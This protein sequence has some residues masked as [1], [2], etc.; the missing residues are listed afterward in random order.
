MKKK[1]FVT[2][3]LVVVISML[4]AFAPAEQEKTV[5]VCVSWNEKVHSLIQAWQDYMEMYAAELTPETGITYE[6]IINVANGD[7]NL[8]N[9]NIQDC[10]N[11]KVDYI[12]ARA[13]DSGTIGASIKAAEAAG[14]PFITFDRASTSGE[15]TTHVGEDG[16]LQTRS[17][18][19]A[20]AALLKEKGVEG[21]CI[22]LQGDLLDNTAVL[23]HNAWADVEKEL[24]AWETIAEVP[25]EWKPEKFYQGA[26]NALQAN[27]DANCMYVASDFAFSSVENALSAVDKL[28]ATGE[29]NH[30]WMAADD[31]NPMGYDAM[32]NGIIDLGTTWEAYSVSV[33]LVDTLNKLV[34]GEPVEKQYLI[35]GRLATPENVNS[36]E[37]LYSLDPKY[38]D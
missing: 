13:Q 6:W 3:L 14:I 15:P 12:V 38:T 19:E 1:I 33:L 21:K 22:E 31:I 11:Q 23:R 26:L 32:V 35:S 8:Q 18:A 16:Y 20:F 9:N 37:F 24:G 34:K 27:P 25:T 29:A 17:T 36:L 10:I 28:A 5:K 4:A 2:L 7:A 30:I